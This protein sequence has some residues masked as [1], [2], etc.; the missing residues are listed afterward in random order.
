MDKMTEL[1]FRDGVIITE[2]TTTAFGAEL[3]ALERAVD[4]A[5]AALPWGRGHD[6]R[7]EHPEQGRRLGR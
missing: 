1:Q 2:Q 7:H 4:A 5:L 3:I 6:R